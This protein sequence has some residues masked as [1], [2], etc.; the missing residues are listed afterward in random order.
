MNIYHSNNKGTFGRTIRFNLCSVKDILDKP[1]LKSFNDLT[2]A[3]RELLQRRVDAYCEETL[4]V[5]TGYTSSILRITKNEISR[6]LGRKIKIPQDIKKADRVKLAK[7]FPEIDSDIDYDYVI[8]LRLGWDPV[9]IVESTPPVLDNF[10]NKP[11]LEQSK[12]IP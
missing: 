5:F 1:E 6:L 10:P 9:E 8:E 11:I 2:E 7:I 3:D 12:Q 4:P